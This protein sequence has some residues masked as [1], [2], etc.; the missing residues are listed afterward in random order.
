M[1]ELLITLI[2]V[3]TANLTITLVYLFGM[4][5]MGYL[6]TRIYKLFKLEGKKK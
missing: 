5:L 1:I 2:I 6:G 3:T 4:V